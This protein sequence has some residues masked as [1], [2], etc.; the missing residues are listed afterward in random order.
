MKR[1]LELRIFLLLPWLL[2]ACFAGP[3][4]TVAGAEE[5]APPTQTEEAD[6]PREITWKEAGSLVD[7]QRYEA[8]SEV[9]E[10]LLA[11][12]RRADDADG[13][14]RALVRL[15]QLRVALHGYEEA[16]RFLREE[17]WP[18][19]AEARTV[20]GLVYG[21]TLYRYLQAY[22]WLIEQRE[23]RS[24]GSSGAGASD[25]A[26]RGDLDTWTREEIAAEIHRAYAGVWARRAEWGDR[27]VGPIARFLRESTYPARIRGTL[28]DVVSHLWVELLADQSLWAPGDSSAASDLELGELLAETP[29]GRDLS[30]SLRDDAVHPLEKIHLVLAD[31]EAWHGESDRPEASFDA[32]RSLIDRLH[33]ALSE[34]EKRSRL[35][36][37]LEA[38]LDDLGREYP[39]WS[40]GM[41]DLAEM[42]EATGDPWALRDARDVARRCRRV[43]YG[44]DSP[45]SERCDRIVRRLEMP[46]ATLRAAATDGPRRRAVQVEHA[47]LERLHF[48]AFRIGDR[49]AWLARDHR[50]VARTDRDVFELL[51]TTP[52]ARWQE[53]LPP[54]PDLRRHTTWVTPPLDEL[55]AYVIVA[56]ARADFSRQNNLLLWVRHHVTNLVL[57]VRDGVESG[58]GKGDLVAEVRSG[59]E[60]RPLRGVSLELRPRRGEDAPRRARTGADGEARFSAVGQGY[61]LLAEHGGDWVHL[62]G[63]GGRAGE[64]RDHLET[65]LFTD[66]AVYRPGQTLHWKAVLFEVTDDGRRRQVQAGH[67]LRLVLRDA[68]GDEVAS[69]EVTTNQWGSA[70]GSFEL[71]TGRLLGEWRLDVQS[72][73]SRLQGRHVAVEEY[74]RPTFEVTIAD[75]EE[76]LRLGEPSRLSGEARYY[77]GLPVSG[78]EVSWRV[79]RVPLFPWWWHRFGPSSGGAETVASGDA[80]T[81]ADGRFEI[82]FVPR[83][84]PAVLGHRRGRS[85]PYRFRLVADV[86][87]EGG[88][89]RDGERVFP[90]GFVTLDV[91]TELPGGVLVSGEAVKIGVLRR[92]L[93]GT[94]RPGEGEW[95][96]HRLRPPE[97]APR[98]PAEIPVEDPWKAGET[99]DEA[100]EPYRTPGD[101][102][103]PRWSGEAMDDPQALIFRWEAGDAVASGDAEH[104]EDG[105]AEVR[106]GELD[107]GA[108]RL[109]YRTEDEAGQEVRQEQGF[110]VYPR[111]GGDDGPALP[112]VLEPGVAGAEPGE[113]VPVLVHTGLGRG[114]AGQPVVF[115]VWRGHERLRRQVLDGGSHWLEV[116]VADADRGGLDLR[117][118]FLRD[119]QH[120]EIRRRIDVP[121]TE[122][123]LRVELATFR[124]RLRPGSEETWT[125]KVTGPEGD[126][127]DATIREATELVASMYDRSLDIF[128]RHAIRDPS[129]LWPVTPQGPGIRTTTQRSES[130]RQRVEGL[131]DL[132]P[133]LSP[134]DA[135]LRFFEGFPVGGPGQRGG[136]MG[137]VPRTMAMAKGAPADMAMAESQIVTAEV[138]A[139]EAPQEAPTDGEPPSPEEPE[140]SEASGEDAL[141]RDFSE[142]ALWEPHLLLDEDGEVSFRFTVPDA[143][144]QWRFWSVALSRDLRGGKVEETARSVRELL[145]RPYLPRF[146]REGDRAELRVVV[147][148]SG[149]ET[150]S[151]TLDFD[152]LDP[153]VGDGAEESRLA[154]FGLDVA[155]VTGVPFEVEPGRET[156]LRFEV[157]APRDPGL[158]AVRVVGGTENLSDGELRPLP[159]LPSR[160]RLAQS[161]FAAL[162]GEAERT[163]RFDDLLEAASDPSLETES[164]VLTLDGQLLATVLHALPY[165]VSYPHECTEQTLNRFVST[166]ILTSVFADHPLVAELARG[167]A[168]ERA[169]E[170]E[171]DGPTRLAPWQSD[172]PNRRALLV[173]TPWLREARGGE[174]RGRELQA[175]L[176]PENAADIRQA[177]LE[178]LRRAQNDDGGFPWFPGGPSDPYVTLYLLDGFSRALEF[179]VEVPREPVQKAWRFLHAHYQ[180]KIEPELGDDDVSHLPRLVY[181][182]WLLSTYPEQG[183][184]T[185]GTFDDADHRRIVGAAFERWRELSPRLKGYLALALN[186]TGRAGDAGTVWASVMDS[187]KTD[188]DLGTW[189]AP[190]ERSWVWYRDTLETHAFALRV[191]GELDPDHP[192]RRGLVQWL[193]LQKKLSHWKSTRATAE[194]IYGLVHYL[195][196]EGELGA[197]EEANVTLAPQ[198]PAE[199]SRR[200]VFEDA[201]DRHQQWA[202]EDVEPAMGEIRVEKDTPGFLFASAT[203]HFATDELPDRA[204]GDLFGIERSYF[205]RELV[206]GEWTLTPLADGARL[207]LGDQ[208]EIHLALRAGHEAEYVHVR[209]PRGAG[210]EPVDLRSGY[211]WNV[212]PHYREI[213]DS[214][215]NF[216][217]DRLPRGEYVFRYRQRAAVAGTFRVGPAQVQSMYAPEFV[218]YSA[219]AEL[220]IGSGERGRQSLGKRR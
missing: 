34:S 141:R 177:S 37:A 203:W 151:G 170:R 204:E 163:L 220:E 174:D 212:V 89:T 165:L 176:D 213:R 111:R 147:S 65:L 157:R 192:A 8:A 85:I 97:G 31:L 217:F 200:F 73:G 190:E 167:L 100:E 210:F 205:R 166:G 136:V 105:R 110:V 52:A 54:T 62:Q 169:E 207:E 158:V 178:R 67:E 72:G 76:S 145:V 41:A 206:D 39:W 51:E 4:G 193:L 189:W 95:T 9:V 90:A 186:R 182:G 35:R 152:I 198:T 107:P 148:N 142:T 91:A 199:T 96:L 118:D 59:D 180:R 161:R 46:Q 155:E 60:G 132:P 71:A 134:R 133:D 106:L 68:N 195:E 156:T 201:G 18:E 88:E 120:L 78:A 25:E 185:Q 3:V 74:E 53:D 63:W 70:S 181:L 114:E 168:E 57:L 149:E 135:E 19:T 160:L 69:E 26:P 211:E 175:L 44:A 143:V 11:E 38:A 40:M 12:A 117:V 33:A 131:H 93:E 17:E 128:G 22:R 191:L 130:G 121:W 20:L 92:G 61:E 218:A 16:V 129:T 6:V 14:L 197:R 7:D 55:G 172:D 58:G 139:E 98:L 171:G 187:A 146:F 209:D 43:E 116:E 32:R 126:P 194:V 125:V 82:E 216:F 10:A 196:A 64:M 184:W 48:R 80:V 49:D 153:T 115:E 27:S 188:E 99:D 1:K 50:R 215:T 28:R 183:G 179:G 87:N 124:D 84:D 173:E 122:K 214:G 30:A 138:P 140:A 164:L 101:R 42:V 119:H 123:K 29:A 127:L 159:V 47:N 24:S 162:E 15:T 109:V 108:Y 144:T 208:V 81:D 94:P 103:R 66:R 83:P 23:T 219:G 150:L 13:E 75:P 102:L 154:D 56:S 79:E 112:L 137:T 86:T 104:G 202:V 5:E 77:F 21:Q 45:G 2:A 36:D 113:T